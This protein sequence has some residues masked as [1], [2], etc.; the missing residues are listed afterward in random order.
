MGDDEADVGQQAQ[1]PTQTRA[2]PLSPLA[3]PALLSH[4]ERLESVV[5]SLHAGDL[6]PALAWAAADLPPEAATAELRFALH[7]AAFLTLLGGGEPFPMIGSSSSGAS[8]GSTCQ[9]RALAYARAHLT[10]FYGADSSNDSGGSE[11]QHRYRSEIHRLLGALVVQPSSHPTT[12]AAGAAASGP[13]DSSPYADLHLPP[14]RSLGPALEPLIRRAF[15]LAFGLAQS[16][17]LDR[18]LR[19]GLD[20][21]VARVEKARAVLAIGGVGV[22]AGAKASGVGAPAAATSTSGG[23][24]TT[25][26]NSA[27]SELPVRRRASEPVTLCS[28]AK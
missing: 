21:G 19:A 3:L 23:T 17:A 4:V 10:S 11:I 14:S 7:K 28:D 6:G 12:T 2:H 22:G 5:C 26:S 18:A 25:A 8:G 27:E 1:D 20:G 9:A 24:D 15:A 13:L 16:P